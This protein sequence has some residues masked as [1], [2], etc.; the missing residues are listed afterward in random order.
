VTRAYWSAVTAAETARVVEQAL[1]RIDAHL[2]D[3]R[4]RLDAGLIPPNEVLTADAQR[5]R[6]QVQVIEARNAAELSLAELRRLADLAPEARVRLTTPLAAPEP[7]A[8]NLTDQIARARSGRPERAALV[9][10]IGAAGAR[11]KA[12]GSSARP[13][14]ALAGGV[15][16]GR[17]NPRIFPRSDQWK[18]SWDVSVN[19]SWSL[20]DGGRR[21]AEVAEASAA[22]RSLRARLEEFDSLIALEVRQ[23]RL[24]L[25]AGISAAGAAAEGVRSAAEARRVV[26]ERFAAGVAASTDML[27]AQ[28]AL[29]QAELDRTR[30]LAAAR[31]AEARLARA[32]GR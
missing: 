5:S 10:R 27:D 12:A 17:P 22:E 28:V 3:L 20:W 21:A 8:G 11:M 6:Q 18:D 25:E 26:D 19:A 30:A 31:I 9:D 1:V 13:A 4:V 16:Y 29:L 24:D 2:R 32:L 14:V 23:R 15:D 7:P